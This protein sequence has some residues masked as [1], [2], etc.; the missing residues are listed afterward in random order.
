MERLR[1]ISECDLEAILGMNAAAVRQTSHLDRGQ[2]QSLVRMASY[3][4]VMAVGGEVAAFLIALREGAPY[5][6]ANYQWFSARF[7]RFLYVDRIVV[8]PRFRKRGI[9][10]RMYADLFGS[11]HGQAVD[12]IACEYNVVPPNPAS[13][14][15]HDRFGFRECGTQWVAE[16]TKQVSLQSAETRQGTAAGRPAA[17]RSD[18]GSPPAAGG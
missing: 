10:G 18:G 4:R 6:S 11:A 16:G 2:L 8:G 5:E 9:G 14:A 17:P 13:R 1:A 3:G 12:M 15:F 7:P